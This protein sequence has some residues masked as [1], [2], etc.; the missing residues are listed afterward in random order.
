MF[1]PPHFEESRAE[2]LH[3][4]IRRHPL[5][6]LVTLSKDGGIVAN[7]I[8][9]LWCESP[10]PLGAL[11]GHVARPNTLWTDSRQDVESLAVFQGPDAY[12]SPSW[13]A[14]KQETG[15]V[16]PTWNYAVVHVYGFLR[17]FD[18]PAWIRSQIERLT[19]SQE[20]SFTEPW[21]VSDAPSEYIQSR[22]GAIVGIELVITRM[23]GKWKMSQNHPE[24][25]RAGV[26]E[27]LR[28]L[29]TPRAAEVADMVRPPRPS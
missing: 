10:A 3:D 19:A 25:N 13:Y 21:R 12:I 20:E 9:L 27:G 23:L 29:G 4:L 18:D 1:T 17:I 11:Q 6:T 28:S 15:R 8:P 22:L 14:T 7:H 24:A 26:I 16:V 5:A 2:V